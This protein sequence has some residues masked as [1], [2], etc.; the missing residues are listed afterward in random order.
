MNSL[1]SGLGGGYEPEMYSIYVLRSLK[2]GKRYVGFTSKGPNIR[3]KEHNKGS[4]DWTSQ[5]KPFV[6]VYTEE[7][8][9]KKEATARERFLKTS[10]GRKY[11]DRT[12][13]RL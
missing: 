10:G 12:K 3:L 13:A 6:L 11:L 4:N 7:Y 1:E 5:N 2:N 9:S 8:N